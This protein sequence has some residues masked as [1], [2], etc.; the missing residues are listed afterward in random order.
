MCVGV[1]NT[2]LG[3]TCS[4]HGGLGEKGNP[5]MLQ[6][7]T[8]NDQVGAWLDAAELFGF[9]NLALLAELVSLKT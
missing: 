7:S 5:H 1:G 6:Q 4:H 9:N 8:W 3:Q 2:S